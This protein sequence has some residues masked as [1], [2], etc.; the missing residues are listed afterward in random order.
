MTS[1]EQEVVD[2]SNRALDE[3]YEEDALGARLISRSTINKWRI[4][5]AS[6]AST[7]EA[8]RLAY[9]LNSFGSLF[10]FCVRG[11]QKHKLQ[12]NPDP[13]KNLHFQMCQTVMKD[14]LKE[15]IEIPRDHFKSTI[16]SECFPIWRALPFKE[17]DADFMRA[18]GYSELFIEWQKRAHR[19]DI[20]MLLVSETIKNAIKLGSRIKK[21]YENNALFRELFPEVLPTTSCTWT[22]DSLHQERTDKGKIHGEG[23]YDFIGVGAALQSR[24][25]DGPIIQDD[26]VGRKAARSEIEMANVI[27]YHQLLVGAMDSDNEDGGRDNDELIV[28][29]RWSYKDLNSHVRANETYFNFITHS[30]LGG[31]CKLHPHGEP[32]FPEA[33]NTRKL[34]RWK[35][36]L[37]TYLFSCQFLNFPINPEQ[38]KFEKKNLRYFH[39]ERTTDALAAPKIDNVNDPEM[40]LKNFRVAIRHHVV[41]GDV[42]EDVFP[43]NLQRYMIIDPNHSGQKGRCR[44]AITITGVSQNPRRV[45][46]LKAW[47]KAIDTNSFVEEIFS[48]A[49]AFKINKIHI[50]TVAA[51]KYLKFHL[52]YYIQVNRYKMPEIAHIKFEDLKSSTTANAKIERIDSVV[53]ITERGELWVDAYNCQ[54]FLEEYEA[55]GNRAGLVDILDTLGY[56]PQVWKFDTVDDLELSRFMNHQVDR[57][58]RSMRASA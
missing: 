39:Y 24:H 45:Y 38:C 42:E 13:R 49:R 48:L 10:Y 17:K 29:N 20:R 33:F 56:G 47:A 18:L 25:Y 41:E 40:K 30:A 31:C 14:G 34:A 46:L 15:V 50:E 51:Q 32:I 58:R 54:E 23:T 2:I 8:K 52:E 16:Y 9:R 28:G 53:P 57:Y 11:L 37:G 3:G 21:H 19:Q 1:A 44:H 36:R 6:T 43:R 4:L 7:W 55:Y 26:L 35:Q 12:S 5:D 22:N 27:E